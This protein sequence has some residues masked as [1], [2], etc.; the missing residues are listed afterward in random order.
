MK[1]KPRLVC[2][3]DSKISTAVVNKDLDWLSGLSIK[4]SQI[5]VSLDSFLLVLGFYTSG[6]QQHIM[7]ASSQ[8]NSIEPPVLGAA[9][10]T[11]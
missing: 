8:P 9:K 4:S 1:N 7:N 3:F 10:W 2:S 6:Q 5:S 11:P